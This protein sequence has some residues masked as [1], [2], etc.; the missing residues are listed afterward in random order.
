MPSAQSVFCKRRT[1]SREQI[2]GAERRN[3]GEVCVHFVLRPFLFRPLERRKDGKSRVRCFRKVPTCCTSAQSTKPYVSRFRHEGGLRPWIFSKRR[4]LFKVAVSGD[5]SG[6]KSFSRVV[7]RRG[8]FLHA[9]FSIIFA[10][11]SRPMQAGFSAS[12]SFAPLSGARTQSPACGVFAK[13]RRAVHLLKVQSLTCRV[14]ALRP[15]CSGRS[16]GACAQA[17]SP[18]EWMAPWR[19]RRMAFPVGS[20]YVILNYKEYNSVKHLMC[21]MSGHMAWRL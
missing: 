4:R 21:F 20:I 7:A 16:G 2:S 12:F 8:G 15:V 6:G 5:C 17:I 9:F 3:S 19:R 10:R 18:S 13:R 1:L 14:F 11:F